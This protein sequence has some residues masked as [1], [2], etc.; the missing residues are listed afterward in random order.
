MGPVALMV[1]IEKNLP[2]GKK[3]AD[4]AVAFGGTS[5]GAI[6]AGLLN[7]GFTALEIRQLYRDNLKK[8]FKKYSVWERLK[9]LKKPTYDHTHLKNLLQE[10][11]KGKCSDWKKPIFIPATRLNG[12][13]CEKVW[14]RGDTD[15]D[16][17][18]AILSSTSAPTYFDVECIDD[19]KKPGE[20]A[21]F[22]DGGMWANSPVA[23]LNAGLCKAG[24]RGTYRILTFDT[25]MDM[26]S[27]VKDNQTLLGWGSYVLNEWVARSG[28][29]G[30]YQVAADI[31]EENLYVLSPSTPEENGEKVKYKMDDV[32]D[33][34]LDALEKIWQDYFEVKKD[35]IMAFVNNT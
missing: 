27:T 11:M 29:S 10:V 4:L 19:K 7:E 12:D 21:W 32:T 33:K 15:V 30:E 35:E 26:L 8:I 9:D 5:T 25:D 1:E 28:R 17:W 31:G 22:C 6:V 14:D 2:E 23:V 3:L 24:Y 18:F 20:K 13:S 16:K 34:T